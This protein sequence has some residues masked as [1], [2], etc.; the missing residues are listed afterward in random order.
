V[1][2]NTGSRKAPKIIFKR[3]THCNDCPYF[4][5]EHETLDQGEESYYACGF[6][7]RIIIGTEDLTNRELDGSLLEIPDWCPLD[8]YDLWHAALKALKGV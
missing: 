5:F 6:T 4:H 2:E 3:V 8:S 7:D 1:D